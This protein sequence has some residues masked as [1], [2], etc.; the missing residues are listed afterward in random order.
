MPQN[1]LC[2][3]KS[4][5]TVLR[6]DRSKHQILA[7]MVDNPAIGFINRVF[8]AVVASNG[9]CEGPMATQDPVGWAPRILPF[10][11]RKAVAR[12]PES[13]ALSCENKVTF[14][15]KPYMRWTVARHNQRSGHSNN[16]QEDF[17]QSRIVVSRSLLKYPTF[18]RSDETKTTS[19]SPGRGFAIQR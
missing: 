19:P 3:V 16:I 5:G 11:D 10:N 15:N 6:I 18:I 7:T 17:T 13:L 12:L 2:V 9:L 1:L 8:N 4:H 14:L